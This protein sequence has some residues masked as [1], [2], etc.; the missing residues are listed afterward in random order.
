MKDITKYQGI[1]PALYACYDDNEYS[2]LKTH[3]VSDVPYGGW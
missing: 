2:F 3:N 1:I